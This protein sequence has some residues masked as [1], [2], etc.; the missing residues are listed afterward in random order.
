[1]YVY[2]CV[3]FKI[4]FLGVCMCI[5]FVYINIVLRN[6]NV[7]VNKN[8]CFFFLNFFTLFKKILSS[9]LCVCVYVCVCLAVPTT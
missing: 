4:Y 5:F 7:Y 1:M 9:Q 8:F 3:S 2:E 6:Y